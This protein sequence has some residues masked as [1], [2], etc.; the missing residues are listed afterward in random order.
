VLLFAGRLSKDRGLIL[1]IEALPRIVANNSDVKVLVIGDGPQ[2]SDMI[3]MAQELNVMRF[4][5]FITSV[6]HGDMPKYICVSDVAIGPLVATIDTY[7]SVP[8]KILEYM[9]CGKLTV[10]CGGGVS[11]DLIIDGYNGFLF[12]P[13]NVQ[14]LASLIISS[15]NNS[16]LVKQV[17]LNARMHIEK[18]HDSDKIMDDF[19]RVLQQALERD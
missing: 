16:D 4:V 15:I 3:K 8:R 11:R 6:N 14:E 18:F 17:R 19:E 5:K 2:K 13:K 10:A 12:K 1:L 9:A 7:G